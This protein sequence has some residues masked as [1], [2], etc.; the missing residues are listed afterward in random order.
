MHYRFLVTFNKHHAVTSHQARRYANDYLTREGFCA[1]EG[2]WVYGMADWF[3]IGGRWSGELSRY[4]WARALYERMDAI[5]KEKGVQVWGAFYGDTEKQKTQK[6]LETQF[7]EMWRKEAPKAYQDIPVNRV[8]YQ[9][10]GYEDDAMILTQE[11][12]DGLLKEYNGESDSEYH[13]DLNYDKVSP[14]MIGKKWIVI[15]DYHN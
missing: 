10:L 12:Y 1:S 11:L 15:V 2:R 14:K 7:A 4:S 6:E 9:E 8:T 5:E 3:V 13:S